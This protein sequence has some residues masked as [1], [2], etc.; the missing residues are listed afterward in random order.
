MKDI[1]Q[2]IKELV[3]TAKISALYA[4]KNKI[5]EEIN[6]LERKRVDSDEIQF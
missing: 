5:Q 4:I 1:D 2:S 3:A 6:E